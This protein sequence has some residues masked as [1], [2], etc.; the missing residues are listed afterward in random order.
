MVLSRHRNDEAPT[1]CDSKGSLSK[2]SGKGNID[3]NI[4]AKTD[5]NFHGLCLQPVQ[6]LD[7]IWLTANQIGC[8]LEYADEKAVQRIYSRHSDE[9]T[10]QM[11]RVVKVTTPYGEQMTRVFSL[12]GAHLVAM[13]AR[14]AIAK[15]F[16]R[17]VLN[18]LDSEI[19][20][21]TSV[22]PQIS[23]REMHSHNVN[24]MFDYFSVMYEAWRYQIE[25]ALRAIE[26]PLAGRLH[27]RFSDGA[28]F[29]KL[30][31]VQADSQLLPG[32]EARIR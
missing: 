5:L 12:R 32:E 7:G 25:P 20:I 2:K 30:I 19:A 28:A 3:M 16:R 17:W 13:F 6:N 27:D 22:K 8:A 29:M 15:E 9:F 24:A 21:N 31:K 18:I 11:S 4:V 1:T 23:D 10:D 26:S 14:T